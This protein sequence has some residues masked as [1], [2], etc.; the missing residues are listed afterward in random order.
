MNSEIPRPS[1]VQFALVRIGVEPNTEQ[2]R[3][4]LDLDEKNYVAVSRYFATSVPSVYAIG[5]VSCPNA[6]TIA[7]AVG[8]AAIAVKELKLAI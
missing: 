7:T 3:G 6:P 8:S 5:D 2:F 4:Q 1:S